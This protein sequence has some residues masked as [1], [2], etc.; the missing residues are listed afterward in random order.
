MNELNQLRSVVNMIDEDEPDF[1]ADLKDAAWNVL[2]ENPGIDMDEWMKVLM[3]QY[4]AEI[5]DALGPHEAKVYE[6]LT[7]LWEDISKNDFKALQEQLN[8]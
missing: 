2:H 6:R 8:I 4:P 3:R 1:F 7:V 5:V